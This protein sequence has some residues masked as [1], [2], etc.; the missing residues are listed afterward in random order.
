MLFGKNC[1]K[2]KNQPRKDVHKKQ[3][4]IKIQSKNKPEK[5]KKTHISTFIKLPARSTLSVSQTLT[6][7]SS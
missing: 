3:H 4:K 6:L 2:Q 1:G 5:A 7:K